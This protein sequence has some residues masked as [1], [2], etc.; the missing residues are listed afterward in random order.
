MRDTVATKKPDALKE[1]GVKY[2]NEE[3]ASTLLTPQH[4][5]GPLRAGEA[6]YSTSLM[7]S[8]SEPSAEQINSYGD[9]RNLKALKPLINQPGPQLSNG[10]TTKDE[11]KRLNLFCLGHFLYR[12]CKFVNCRWSHDFLPEVQK[13]SCCKFY[14]F[15]LCNYGDNC[16]RGHTCTCR[17]IFEAAIEA[18]RS[19]ALTQNH[20]HHHYQ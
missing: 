16:F 4:L 2:L 6:G 12:S 19:S 8:Y 11:V 13:C 7:P 17:N 9:N 1:T 5:T 10:I 3:I 20:Q 15:G 18:A 14:L